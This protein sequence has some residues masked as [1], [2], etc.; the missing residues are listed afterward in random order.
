MYLCTK[1]GSPIGFVDRFTG[2]T[3]AKAARAAGDIQSQA[4]IDAAGNVVDAGRQA[5]AIV[6]SAG[7][8]A[9]SLQNE[10]GQQAG[11]LFD[12]FQQVGQQGV[13]QAGF[14]TDPQAQFDF[15]QN[16]P[17]FQLGLDN[18]NTQTNQFA[19]ARGRLSA[20]DTFQ[21]LNQNALLTASPLI[22][23]QKQSIGDL[24]GIGQFAA[25]NQSGILQDVANNR[26]NIT[27]NTA[28]NRAN[29][30]QNT[31]GNQGN[32]LTGAAAAQAGGL[33]GAENARSAGLGN[34]LN[35]GSQI[36]GFAF[37]GP[38]G[39]AAAGTPGG[40]AQSANQ[41]APFNPLT[42][43]DPALKTN[44]KSIGTENGHNI[45]SW[46]WNSKANAIG[47]NGS[48]S[49]VMADEIK[50]TNPEAVTTF[51]DGFMRVDYKAIGVKH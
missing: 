27:Q 39:V 21:Q 36:G 5:G 19:A 23:Q 44:I 42:A 33:V 51:D 31:A 29:I 15:L 17:L 2:K 41:F 8:R 7:R 45:Y 28:L 47:L 9:G 16:N 14:L 30:L 38:A 24:L 48:D 3:A 46:D 12:P 50:E 13:D 37:G 26:A 4:A 10:A 32:L 6:Q 11:A 25:G 35:L 43:S 1:E 49:G 34:I 40:V 20:G 22:Q 18:A